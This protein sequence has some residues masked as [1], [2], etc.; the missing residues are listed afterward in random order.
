MEWRPDDRFLDDKRQPG[1]S[2]V[3]GVL[4]KNNI[5]LQVNHVIT[6]RDPR[7]DQ[8]RYD[9]RRENMPP[10]WDTWQLP[11]YLLGQVTFFFLTSSAPGAILP[12]HAHD[13]AQV[14][15]VLSGGLHYNDAT[16]KSGELK[17][18]D[19][20]YIPPKVAYSLTAS[21]NPGGAVHQ[22]MY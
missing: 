17:S 18:G 15:I 12:T 5:S 20:M 14:R 1:Q 8:A 7:W 16:G 4:E 10:G 13:I 21:L 3:D 19:W 6:S 2:R 9:L 11:F 22:Y